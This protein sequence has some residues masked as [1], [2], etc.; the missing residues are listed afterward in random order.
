MKDILKKYDK[1]IIAELNMGQLA[2]IIRSEFCVNTLQINKM[3]GTPFL[4]SELKDQIKKCI[5]IS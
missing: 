3:Q 2:Q 4:V 5:D 1:I